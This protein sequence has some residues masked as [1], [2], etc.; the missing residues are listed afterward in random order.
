MANDKKSPLS[1]WMALN[2]ALLTMDEE[3]CKRLIKEEQKGRNR[4]RVVLRI[5]A[6]LN[7]VRA[8]REREALAQKAK[9]G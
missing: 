7:K 6:R 4:R 1:S 3:G 5:H 9:F 2:A 8:H